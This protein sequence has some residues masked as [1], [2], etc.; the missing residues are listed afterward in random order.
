MAHRELD[1]KDR[2][3]SVRS[4]RLRKPVLIL[5]DLSALTMRTKRVFRAFRAFSLMIAGVVLASCAGSQSL[6]GSPS[7]S[8][9]PAVASP[10]HS[11]PPARPTVPGPHAADLNRKLLNQRSRP[12]ADADLPLGPGDLVEVSVFDVQELSK[13][14]LRIPLSG[15][16]TLPLIGTIAAAGLTAAE[17]QNEIR[18]RLQEKYMHD[19]QV[20]LFVEEHKSQRISVVGAVRKGGVFPLSSRMRLADALGM[21][22]GL[23]EEAGN[24]VYV[25]RRVPAESAPPAH[26]HAAARET[27]PA[28]TGPASPAPPEV[29]MQE[30][31]TAV[32]LGA[33]VGGQEDLNLPLQPGDVIDVPRAGSY[34]VG[35][36]VQRPGSFLLKSRT[37][38]DQA[39]VAAGGVKDV[40]DWDDV[41]LY[42][43]G[44]G[45]QRDVSRFSVN[46]FE[47]GKPAPEVRK[48]DVIIVGKSGTKAFFYGVRDFFRFAWGAS[49]PVK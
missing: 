35:G 40:A 32:D 8:P 17:L 43:A 11:I 27:D 9:A 10:D 2:P 16:I 13:L 18:A 26:A 5:D 42:R 21:A 36:E 30:V 1:T 38:V 48:E 46:D 22:D 37:T 7:V 25:I 47:N 34:Y 12:P 15:T 41:R 31:M 45:G 3:A 19:P 14:K 28:A 6:S 29:T 44:S 33:L 39:I 4:H 20:S 24:I 49:L 23:S